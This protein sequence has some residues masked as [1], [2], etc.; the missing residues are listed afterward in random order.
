MNLTIMETATSMIAFSTFLVGLIA[1]IYYTN[2]IKG[3]GFIEMFLV[4]VIYINLNLL[5]LLYLKRRW[6]KI[7][8]R[9]GLR[10]IGLLSYW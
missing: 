9:N 6:G 10:I 8:L 4:L 3:L 2:Q 1:T 7:S 5:F